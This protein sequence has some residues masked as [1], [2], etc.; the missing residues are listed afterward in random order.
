MA[1]PSQP[2]LAADPALSPSRTPPFSLVKGPLAA[3]M[4]DAR[5]R[6]G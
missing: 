2:D 4:N 1:W 6:S 5:F 3:S